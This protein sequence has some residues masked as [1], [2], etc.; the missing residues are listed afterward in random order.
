LSFKVF[1][2][3]LPPIIQNND[4]CLLFDLC[5]VRID[6]IFSQHKDPI[7][8]WSFPD[9][10]IPNRP[11]VTQ[12]LK[13]ERHV[14]FAKGFTGVAEAHNFAACYFPTSCYLMSDSVTAIVLGSEK[15]SR[16]SLRH[17]MTR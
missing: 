11:D 16:V 4:L 5:R 2:D 17:T 10:N 15:N 7:T 3:G 13:S 14:M 8:T 12:L 1:W 6:L 9:S